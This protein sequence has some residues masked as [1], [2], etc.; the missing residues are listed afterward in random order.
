MI[1]RLPILFFIL[2]ICTWSVVAVVDASPAHAQTPDDD[3][4]DDEESGDDDGG[5]DE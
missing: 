1:R 4:W 2:V 3:G 5:S